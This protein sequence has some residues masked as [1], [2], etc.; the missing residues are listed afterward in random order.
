[1]HLTFLSVPFRAR[2]LFRQTSL[3]YR[4]Y[5]W[6]TF[7][8][9]AS[10]VLAFLIALPISSYFFPS[11]SLATLYSSLPFFVITVSFSKPLSFAK[12]VFHH[13]SVLDQDVRVHHVVDTAWKQVR[14]Q[15]RRDTATEIA[16]LIVASLFAPLKQN[17]AGGLKEFCQL[18]ALVLAIDYIAM[19][20]FLAAVFGVVIEVCCKRFKNSVHS[21]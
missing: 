18:A 10:G 17:R 20:V 19:A 3:T 15:I 16:V 11:I 4:P 8:I 1:M 5:F 14:S 6:I 12:A 7:A 13:P 21:C 2:D 9:L